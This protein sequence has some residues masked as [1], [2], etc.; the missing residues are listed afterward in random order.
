[1]ADFTLSYSDSSEGWPSFYSFVPDW[2]VGM[3]NRFYSFNKGNL[4]LHNSDNAARN[5]YYGVQYNT[6]VLTIFNDQPLENKIF[7]T[8]SLQ[9]DDSWDVNI[10]SDIQTS[11]RIDQEWFIKKEQEWYSYIRNLGSVPVGEE[12]LSQRS[13]SGIA[14]STSVTGASG[15]LIAN[16]DL[17]V[18]I[19]S[20]LSVGDYLY[21]AVGPSFSSPVL[22]G[23]VTNIEVDKPNSINRITFD[24]TI[25]GATNPP[26]QTDYY[27]FVKDQTAE[28]HGILG[29]Y[30]EVLLEN[31]NIA[32]TELFAVSSEVMI[33]YP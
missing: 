32:I 27:L 6:K 2:M 20:F 22:T 26:N 21:Y 24:D 8:I 9:G 31:D 7:K 25:G 18:N 4:Y 28:S 10:N 33:S 23:Q 12:Q 11:G 1:M 14:Q 17:A 15:A 19:G 5:N 16:F 30:A 29:H 13:I 3:N